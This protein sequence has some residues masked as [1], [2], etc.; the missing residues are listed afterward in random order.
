[1]KSIKFLVV[2]LIALGLSVSLVAAEIH[3]CA[4]RG[5]MTA[6]KSIVETDPMQIHAVDGKC[7]TPVDVAIANGQMSI[8]NGHI[9]R[10]HAF[11][12]QGRQY[13][14]KRY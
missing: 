12:W 6:V 9:H 7:M 10:C 4:A 14:A 5:D 3:D 11:D 2:V 1:M 13:S 8:C